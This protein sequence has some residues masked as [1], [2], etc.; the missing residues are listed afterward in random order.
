[1][2]IMNYHDSVSFGC[3]NMNFVKS[4][5]ERRRHFSRCILG[6]ESRIKKFNFVYVYTL[7]SMFLFYLFNMY[8][9]IDYDK[10]AFLANIYKTIFSV[11]QVGSQFF[12]AAAL[13]NFIHFQFKNIKF[14][15]FLYIAL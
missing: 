14:L 15:L 4:F 5:L 7:G 9:A 1:M 10:V 8:T 13:V 6:K 11:Y 12:I 3:K 2:I